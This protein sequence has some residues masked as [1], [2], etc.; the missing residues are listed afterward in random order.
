VIADGFVFVQFSYQ[1]PAASFQLI[2]E[3][4]REA[5]SGKLVA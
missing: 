2:A 1:L 5:G 3:H 4:A